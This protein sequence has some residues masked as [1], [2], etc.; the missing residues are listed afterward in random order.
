MK[1]CHFDLGELSR[2]GRHFLR[3]VV[4]QHSVLMFCPCGGKARDIFER[5]VLCHGDVKHW[6]KYAKFEVHAGQ[7]ANSRAVYERAVEYFG[8]ENMSEALLLG[9]AQFEEQQK[10]VRSLRKR[11]HPHVALT[12]S[13]SGVH[14]Y[15]RI[16]H[17]FSTRTPC[18]ASPIGTTHIAAFAIYVTSPWQWCLCACTMAV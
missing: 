5:L 16:R 14:R 15:A 11:L 10:E 7:V 1:H 3:R 8:E 4:P 18:T 12:S 6:I 13:P 17:F 2:M 9:F